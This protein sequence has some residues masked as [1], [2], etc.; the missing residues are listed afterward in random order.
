MT[1]GYT[2]GVPIDTDPAMGLNSNQVVP[3]QAAVVTYVTASVLNVALPVTAT[4]NQVLL[5]RNSASPVWSTTT[6]P[7]TNAVS[8]LLYASSANVMAAL[9]TANNSI[10]ITNGSGVPSWTSSPTFG[11]LVTLN[12]GQVVKRTA[13]AISYTVLVTDYYIGITDNS[14]ART[15]TL[16]AAPSTNQIFVIKDEAGTAASTN[17]ITIT[18][19]GGIITI[20]GSTTK[21]LNVNYQS[22]SVIFNGISYFIF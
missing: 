10:L 6:Y 5:S 8:T 22:V 15:I 18:V 14:A 20:D 16:P 2:K 12:A 11:G 3:S 4:A 7:S 19:A 17:N 13:T 21:L 1:Q 9:P